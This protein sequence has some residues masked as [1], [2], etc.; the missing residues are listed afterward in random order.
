MAREISTINSR[1]LK[2]KGMINIKEL[3]SLEYLSLY[4]T[5]MTDAGLVYLKGLTNLREL[6]LDANNITDAGLENLKHL[7]K[8]EI[9]TINNSIHSNDLPDIQ[10]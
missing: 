4:Q 7:R 1:M 8:L 5:E 3:T 10:A 9:L 6:I 2:E